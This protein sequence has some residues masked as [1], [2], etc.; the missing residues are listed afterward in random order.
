MDKM[1]VPIFKEI[2]KDEFIDLIR[3]YQR[4]QEEEFEKLRWAEFGCST[5]E[6]FM[7]LLKNE[8]NP[9]K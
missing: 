4:V 5:K 7:Q 1:P 3:D 6:V 9:L 2:M 8:I